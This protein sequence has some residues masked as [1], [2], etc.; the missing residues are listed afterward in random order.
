MLAKESVEM[1][2]NSHVTS[3]AVWIR[4][5]DIPT[6]MQAEALTTKFYFKIV[7][8]MTHIQNTMREFIVGFVRF[9]E[10]HVA[11]E[12]QGLTSQSIRHSYCSSHI[13]P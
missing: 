6:I 3:S 1:L 10:D 2:R 7:R 5:I 13:Q 11:I 8:I 4:R 9:N 12:M